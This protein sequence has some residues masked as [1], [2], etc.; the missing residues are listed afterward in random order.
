MNQLKLHPKPEHAEFVIPKEAY[1]SKEWFEREQSELF[2]RCWQYACSVREIPNHGDYV[3]FQAGNH[4]LIIINHKGEIKA[5]HNVCR[6]R[7]TKLL[8][9]KGCSAAGIRCPYH[10]WFYQTDGALRGIAK[11]DE[12]FPGIDKNELGLL[13]ANVGIWKG[14]VFV[15]PQDNCES[16]E[17]W[18]AEFPDKAG[19]HEPEELVEVGREEHEIKSNWKLVV[20]NYFDGYHLAQLHATTLDAYDHDHSRWEP[21]GR[22]VVWWEP[23]AENYESTPLYKM[24]EFAPDLQGMNFKETGAHVH[25]MFPNIGYSGNAKLF[26]IFHITPLAP[27]LTRV[28]LITHMS[29]EVNSTAPVSDFHLAQQREDIEGDFLKS[30]DFFAE[31]VE[32]CERMQAG[33]NSPNY[34]PGPLAQ[35]MEDTITFWQ[36]NVLEYVPVNKPD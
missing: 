9:G 25:M 13:P 33:M 12:Y 30:G 5:F 19:P 6:H 32:V 35:T 36:Q 14:L 1:T 31:D 23:T 3:T 27:D 7:A 2:G 17:E 21:A 16:L 24:L 34:V 15:N 20:E 18:L 29:P 8:E 28:E 26:V 10:N 4:P 11:Q 22:H